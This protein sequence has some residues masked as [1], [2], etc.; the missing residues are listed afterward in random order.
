MPC[1][2]GERRS[3][4][5]G[6]PH[7]Q[8]QGRAEHAV[9]AGVRG[10]WGPPAAAPQP[11]HQ[12]EPRQHPGELSG[13]AWGWQP[14]GGGGPVLPCCAGIACLSRADPLFPPP[15][16]AARPTPK[17]MI[18]GT[19]SQNVSMS[20]VLL[21]CAAVSLDARI[22]CCDSALPAWHMCASPSRVQA[23][24]QGA[25]VA[26]PAHPPALPF[27]PRPAPFRSGGP[28]RRVHPAA[29]PAAPHAAAA[30]EG[31]GCGGR[32]LV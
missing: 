9:A 2:G 14:P 24:P 22:T 15:P 3:Q 27:L 4:G 28:P 23:P 6:P 7:F 25:V 12:H 11:L 16:P 32:G 30:A 17:W 13:P 21:A 26:L 10:S 29:A 18:W 31:S 1:S 5:G 20:C 8:G 19:R